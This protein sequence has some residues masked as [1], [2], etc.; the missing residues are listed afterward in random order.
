MLFRLFWSTY[1]TRTSRGGPLGA[2]HT[3]LVSFLKV[4]EVASISYYL[5]SFLLLKKSFK[6]KAS[7]FG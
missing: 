5:D 7:D 2:V 4:T 6:K 1:S 3:V